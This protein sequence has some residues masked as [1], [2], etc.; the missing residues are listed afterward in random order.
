MAR[1]QTPFII[2]RDGVWA[3]WFVVNRPKALDVSVYVLNEDGTRGE[4]RHEL[5]YPSVPGIG[6]S[7]FMPEV[8]HIFREYEARE[9]AEKKVR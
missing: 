6:F 7:D 5:R 9:Y 3:E 2:K 8:L 4:L 1:K